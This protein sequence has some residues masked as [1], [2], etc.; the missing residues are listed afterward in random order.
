MKRILKKILTLLKYGMIVFL[1]FI[2]LYFV[3]LREWQMTWGASD[4]DVTR[5]MAGDELLIDPQFNATR[6]VKINAPPEKIW[7]WIVQMGYKRA[8]FYSYDKLDNA[9]IP[10]SVHIIPEY[11]DLKV[12]DP[13]RLSRRSFMKVLEI[14]PNTST[15]WV[16]QP[17]P[18]LGLTWSWYL[19]KIDSVH[20]KL[21]SRVRWKYR[22]KNARSLIT[23]SLMDVFEIV[24]MRKCL[25]GIKQRAEAGIDHAG[26]LR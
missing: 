6:A 14:E 20:T 21:V 22:I 23:Y 15:L 16:F 7:P 5:H 25:L 2:F 12:G 11:Q 1:A 9:G 24:M 10:S 17:K 3:W 19:Y 13:V 18:P 4:E 8:G 26:I